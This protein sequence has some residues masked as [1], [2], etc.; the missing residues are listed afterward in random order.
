L[1]YGKSTPPTLDLAGH[2]LQ[3]AQAYAD[4][5]GITLDQASTELVKQELTERLVTVKP[6]AQVIPFKRNR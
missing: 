5:R 6:L 4:S 2:A 3:Q 1:S